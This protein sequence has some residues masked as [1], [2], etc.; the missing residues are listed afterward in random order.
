MNNETRTE[1]TKYT[2]GSVILKPHYILL[3]QFLSSEIIQKVKD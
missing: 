1:T 2:F 3:L